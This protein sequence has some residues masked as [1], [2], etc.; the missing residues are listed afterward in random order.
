MMDLES[1]MCEI[2][3]PNTTQFHLHVDSK[4]QNKTEP[5]SQIQETNHWLPERRG[6]K[7]VGEIGEGD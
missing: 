2:S 5:D 7:R 4:K 3:Q 1:I 6:V